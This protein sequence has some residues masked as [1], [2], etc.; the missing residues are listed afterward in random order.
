[1]VNPLLS[2]QVTGPRE[3]NWLVEKEIVDEVDEKKEGKVEGG[4]KKKKKKGKKRK[5]KSEKSLY[6]TKSRILH[7]KYHRGRNICLFEV[8]FLELP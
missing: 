1:M 8:P 5:K 4:E 2:S 3:Q 7:P 6:V